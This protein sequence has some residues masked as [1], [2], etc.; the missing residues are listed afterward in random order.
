[1]DLVKAIAPN[2]EIEYIGIREG[3]KLHEEMITKSDAFTTIDLKPSLQYSNRGRVMN[4]ITQNLP[5]V[6]PDFSCNSGENE[7]FLSVQQIR[8]RLDNTLIQI[9]SNPCIFLMENK[10]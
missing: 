9:L 1:M 2:T 7:H 3:E 5:R 10:I 4:I 8:E 6:S